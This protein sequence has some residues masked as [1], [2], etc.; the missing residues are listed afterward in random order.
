MS[1]HPMAYFIDSPARPLADATPLVLVEHFRQSS[2]VG[3]HLSLPAYMLY[4]AQLF[5]D[6][7]EG[8]LLRTDSPD[9]LVVDL[10]A[11]GWLYI[12]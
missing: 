4:F 9:H 5:E 6:F 3:R 11:Y 8:L 2:R 7:S 10:I 1:L 12:T